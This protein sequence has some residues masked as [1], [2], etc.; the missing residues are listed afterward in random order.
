M[1]TPSYVCPLTITT[2]IAGYAARTTVSSAPATTSVPAG[3]HK[4]SRA[5]SSEPDWSMKLVEVLLNV[6]LSVGVVRI[7]DAT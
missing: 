7:D 1:Q 5:T 3:Q 2:T 6:R 4:R